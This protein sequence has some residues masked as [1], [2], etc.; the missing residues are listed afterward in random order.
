MKKI[1]SYS[2]IVVCML[3]GLQACK[4]DKFLDTPVPSITDATFFESDAAALSVLPGVYDPAGWGNYSQ[5]LQWAIGDVVSDDAVKGGGGDGDQPQ[6]IFPGKYKLLLKVRL[7]IPM[8]RGL[9]L[10]LAS[11]FSEANQ[12]LPL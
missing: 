10:Q 2:V 4:P 12:E 5:Y 11:R 7:Q 8:L 9:N 3:L 1:Y 6:S